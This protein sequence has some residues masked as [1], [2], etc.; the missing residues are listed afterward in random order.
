MEKYHFSFT[1]VSPDCFGHLK[2]FSHLL[3]ERLF[4]ELGLNTFF[5][6]YKNFAKLQ[7]DVM[8]LL[9]TDTYWSGGMSG[10]GEIFKCS[11][12]IA[13]TPIER[14]SLIIVILYTCGS[15]IYFIHWYCSNR[16]DPYDRRR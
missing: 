16:C 11:R 3:L 6:S 8:A 1:E 9:D 2:L 10:E 13:G 12:N 7:Y 4:E 14:V 5:F 15:A